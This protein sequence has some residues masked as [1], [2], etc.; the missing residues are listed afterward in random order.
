MVGLSAVMVVRGIGG[1]VVRVC[2]WA[3]DECRVMA[4]ELFSCADGTQGFPCRRRWYTLRPTT[5]V[6]RTEQPGGRTRAAGEGADDTLTGQFT[7]AG[8][9]HF[10][11]IAYR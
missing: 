11:C 4:S 10:P 7:A 9:Q 8:E 1:A 3:Q 6:A 2:E 5:I